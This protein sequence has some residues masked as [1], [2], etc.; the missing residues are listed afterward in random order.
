MEHFVKDGQR[1]LAGL[2]RVYPLNSITI[3]VH[4]AYLLVSESLAT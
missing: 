3:T 1:Q 2:G 4:W